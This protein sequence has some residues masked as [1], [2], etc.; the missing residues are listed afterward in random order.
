MR[1]QIHRC[2]AF[3]LKEPRF[4]VNLSAAH[5]HHRFEHCLRGIY[6]GAYFAVAY[7]RI[8]SVLSDNDQPHLKPVDHD[9]PQSTPQGVRRKLC[10]HLQ[11][12]RDRRHAVL[13]KQFF[14]L[15]QLL[16]RFLLFRPA[17]GARRLFLFL[18]RRFFRPRVHA[19]RHKGIPHTHLKF[20]PEPQ[21]DVHRQQQKQQHK[22]QNPQHDPPR[23]HPHAS[24]SFV[25]SGF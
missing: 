17:V 3:F 4:H 9:H 8:G 21:R 24:L 7:R 5:L 14:Q 13:L 25:L 18:F 22:R 15:W 1:P 23:C 10:H 19:Q 12:R 2:A 20:F 11:V 16:F 6:G